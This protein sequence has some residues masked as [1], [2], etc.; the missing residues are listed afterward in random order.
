M[1]A[2]A[3][4]AWM[5]TVAFVVTGAYALLRCSATVAGPLPPERR[6]AELAHVVMSVS[7]VVMTWSWFS[8]TGLVLQV[9]LFSLF[10]A[11]FAT[12]AVRGWRGTA[13]A[14]VG[15]AA[16]ALMAAAMVWML[17]SMP[18]VMAMPVSGSDGEGGH[19]GHA[20]HGGGSAGDA[21]A[22]GGQ[23]GWAVAVTLA[24]SV[25]LLV[26]CGY[27]ALRALRREPVVAPVRTPALVGGGESEPAAAPAPRPVPSALGERS[28]AVC[29]AVMSL[30]MVVMFVG[31][32]AGW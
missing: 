3:P 22:M 10:T 28:D 27:W 14:C 13:H 9:V 29:H 1:I 16:H 25:A 18:L 2:S 23:A 26:A 7:M 6:T 17:V 12:R 24:V 8:T 15:G 32:V 11:Y 19:A 31:M 20:G 5:L 4:L 21:M 30:G